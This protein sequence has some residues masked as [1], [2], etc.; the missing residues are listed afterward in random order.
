LL[1]NQ[2]S[3]KTQKFLKKISKGGKKLNPIP[4]TSGG[5]AMAAMGKVEEAGGDAI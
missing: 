4:R 2:D 3:T 5:A 1:S